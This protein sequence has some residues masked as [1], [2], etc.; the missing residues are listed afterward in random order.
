M[1]PRSSQST[2][3][4]WRR[5][6]S[7]SACICSGT[8]AVRPPRLASPYRAADFF[9]VAVAVGHAVAPPVV[10]GSRWRLI[11]AR[12]RQRGE[13]ALMG[14]QPQGPQA[15]G[16]GNPP[17][18][19]WAKNMVPVAWAGAR[20]GGSRQDLSYHGRK[21]VLKGNIFCLVVKLPL[22]YCCSLVF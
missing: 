3:Q 20:D 11:F 4:T 22:F 18:S 13:I 6:V 16:E 17:R 14:R 9:A 10:S 21:P 15:R 1:A 19:V 12:D 5:P 8:I 2:T 7:T